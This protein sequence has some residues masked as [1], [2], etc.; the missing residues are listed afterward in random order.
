MTKNKQRKH[1]KQSLIKTC[2]I[3]DNQIQ[4]KLHPV[5]KTYSLKNN[6]GYWT[7]KQTDQNKYAC[8]DC[9]TRILDTDY[10]Y[11]WVDDKEKAS[12][13][14]TYLYRGQFGQKN[15]IKVKQNAW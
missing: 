12:T 4:I 6:W 9:L 10:I 2:F 8:D 14:R 13:F 15:L 11:E 3:C 5:K 1:T 7:N